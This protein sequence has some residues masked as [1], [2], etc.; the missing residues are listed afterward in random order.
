MLGTLDE[1]IIC[2]LRCGHISNDLR[3]GCHFCEAWLRD[4]NNQG[5]ICARFWG[6]PG[7]ADS[8]RVHR[9]VTFACTSAVESNS[10][11]DMCATASSATAASSWQPMPVPDGPS[12]T[13]SS[14]SLSGRSILKFNPWPTQIH[15][16]RWTL[17][18]TLMP[19]GKY[20]IILV[21]NEYNY[22]KLIRIH[23]LIKQKRNALSTSGN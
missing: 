5:E 16:E 11:A 12:C 18:Q 10:T 7:N 4:M 1:S 6:H 9:R 3:E 14:T 2:R 23:M 22:V 21:L 17:P 19:L 8:H 13:M 15:C 20:G